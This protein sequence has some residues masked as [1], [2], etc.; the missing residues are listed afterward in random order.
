MEKCDD[1]FPGTLCWKWPHNNRWTLISERGS[2]WYTFQYVSSPTNATSVGV[3]T[4]SSWRKLNFRGWNDSLIYI[5]IFFS[6]TRGRRML[7][8]F[9]SYYGAFT[10]PHKVLFRLYCGFSLR[11]DIKM[12]VDRSPFI[13]S[14][15]YLLTQILILMIKL[16]YCSFKVWT[17]CNYWCPEMIVIKLICNQSQAPLYWWSLI[18]IQHRRTHNT[19]QNMAPAE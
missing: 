19:K 4:H 12:D 18:S 8:S 5:S 1:L 11:Q 15:H 3:S 16:S 14:P 9:S 13:H 7:M 10:E 6:P 2:T 17:K